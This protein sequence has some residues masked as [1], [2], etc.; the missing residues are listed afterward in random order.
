M[1]D[2]IMDNWEII[3]SFIVF[4]FGAFGWK[5]LSKQ[6]IIKL[7][8]IIF[9]VIETLTSSKQEVTE[10]NFMSELATKT[11]KNKKALTIYNKI[12]D[13]K[14]DNIEIIK[15]AKKAKDLIEGVSTIGNG[16]KQAYKLFKGFTKLF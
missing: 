15:T 2:F 1:L 14:K 5:F 7:W 11:L 3:G 12:R 4:L 10:T 16:A 8:G 9:E 13:S 6:Q